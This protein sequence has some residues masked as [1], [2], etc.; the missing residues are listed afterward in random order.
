MS[1]AAEITREQGA[2]V[3]GLSIDARHECNLRGT[4]HIVVEDKNGRVKHTEKVRNGITN[5][6]K[7]S[8][9]DIMF[10]AATQITTW[11]IGLIDNSGWTAEAAA[12]TLASHSGWNEFTSY[13]GSRLEWTEGA[14]ASQSITNGTAVSFPITGSGTLKG[15]FIASVASGTSGKLWSTADFASTVTVAN[16]DTLK[17]TY[18]IN[19]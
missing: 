19:A 10:H 7:N 9:L 12:D 13:T 8:L 1:A 4:F 16:G 2:S 11:Y 17:I 6:G 15:I 3:D 14:A 18:T 5:E